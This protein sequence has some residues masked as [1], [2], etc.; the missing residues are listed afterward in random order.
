MSALSVYELGVLSSL[1]PRTAQ[2]DAGGSGRRAAASRA[3]SARPTLRTPRPRRG[4]R[5]GRAARRGGRSRGARTAAADPPPPRRRP[6]R[7]RRRRAAA[8]GAA[9]AGRANG[10][11]ARRGVGAPLPQKQI[12]EVNV[13]DAP[14]GAP[15]GRSMDHPGDVPPPWRAPPPTVHQWQELSLSVAAETLSPYLSW[16]PLTTCLHANRFLV[17]IATA[18]SGWLPASPGTE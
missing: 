15:T 17:A 12:E 10:S 13:G 5:A 16:Q 11:A 3:A 8:R 6:P 7:R 18:L 1:H 2:G 9:S 14:A 4:A